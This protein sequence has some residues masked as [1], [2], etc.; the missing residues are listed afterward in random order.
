MGKVKLKTLVLVSILV[1]QDFILKKDAIPQII[2]DA[3][4]EVAQ[5]SFEEFA[6]YSTAFLKAHTLTFLF[7]D[8]ILAMY[9]CNANDLPFILGSDMW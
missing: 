4:N 2:A 9:M 7:C 6:L 5:S 8:I 1:V 3:I